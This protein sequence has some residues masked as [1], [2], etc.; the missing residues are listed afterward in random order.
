MIEIA[1][2]LARDFMKKETIWIVEGYEMYEPS[3]AIIA[4][5]TKKNAQKYIENKKEFLRWDNKRKTRA[6][7]KDKVGKK[8]IS[9]DVYFT[10]GL[11]LKR[12]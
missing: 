5:S 1:G 9:F 2:F 8:T 3:E 11:T 10:Y 4:F 6:I 7:L 12:G